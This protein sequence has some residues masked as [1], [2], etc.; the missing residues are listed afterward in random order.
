MVIFFYFYPHIGFTASS[1]LEIPVGCIVSGVADWCQFVPANVYKAIYSLFKNLTGYLQNLA[2][3]K[4]ISGSVG[5]NFTGFKV[6][7]Y[8]S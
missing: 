8:F 4:Y 2:Q 6:N 5:F 7:I 1:R 3:E